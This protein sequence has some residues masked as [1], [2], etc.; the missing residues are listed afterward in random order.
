MC[1]FV[2][3]SPAV[4]KQ[5]G[6]RISFTSTLPGF[7]E[8]RLSSLSHNKEMPVKQTDPFITTGASLF[9]KWYFQNGSAQGKRRILVCLFSA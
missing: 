8:T 3:D 1:L 6:H 9:S 7:P 4:V 2:F 5:V